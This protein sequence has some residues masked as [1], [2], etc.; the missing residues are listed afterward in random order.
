MR[1]VEDW[2]R[3]FEVNVIGLV[4]VTRACLPRLRA[5]GGR[6]VNI[7]SIGGRMALPALGAYNASK[8]AVRAISDLLRQELRS[9]GVSVSLIEPGAI[10]TPIW[11]K[12]AADA[13]ARA[14]E[15]EVEA[16]YAPLVAKIIAA[17]GKT[18]RG[19]APAS[20]VAKAAEHALVSPRPK[21]NYV[22]GGD[23]RIQAWI[24]LLPAR[25]RDALIASQL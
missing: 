3:Q 20:L 24:A 18:A 22:V 7:G 5:S 10:D 1:S 8:F 13:E 25:W 16:V 14:W 6:I 17:A 21:T 15:P 19:A 23:A 9:L 4:A 2:R 11:G 12:S